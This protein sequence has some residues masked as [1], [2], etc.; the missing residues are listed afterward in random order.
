VHHLPFNRYLRKA[1]FSWK[2]S[3]AKSFP[4]I[5]AHH[6]L[7]LPTINSLIFE[8]TDF[9]V[10]IFMSLDNVLRGFNDIISWNGIVGGFLA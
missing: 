1:V 8:K 7:S 3:R 10:C 6:K 5:I 9:G 2:K 4:Y